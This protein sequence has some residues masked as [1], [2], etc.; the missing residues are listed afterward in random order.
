MEALRSALRR[1]DIFNIINKS[2]KKNKLPL[3]IWG[4]TRAAQPLLEDELRRFNDTASAGK[5]EASGDKA[6][7]QSDTS[8]VSGTGASGRVSLIVTYDDARA[9]KLYSDYRFMSRD[10][11]IYPAKD[12]LFY[13]ADVHGNATTQRRLEIIRRLNEKKDTV[14][15]TTVDGLMD[16]MPRMEEITGGGMSFTVGEEINIEAVRTSLATLGYENREIVEGEGQF[17][18]RGG[19]IDIYP[20]TEDCPYRIELF[21]DEIVSIRSFD[22]DSQRSI[23][24]IKSFGIYPASEFV[25]SPARIARGLRAIED[26]YEKEAAALK[27]KFHTEQYARLTRAVNTIKEE[28]GEFNSTTGLDSLVNYFYDE[29]VSF[30]DYL[31]KD[32]PVFIDEPDKVAERARVY[33]EEFS[34]SMDARLA[35]GYVLSKQADVL[36]SDKLILEMLGKRRTIMFSEMYAASRFMPAAETLEFEGK[37]IVTYSSSFESLTKDLSKWRDKDYSIVIASPSATRAKR[38][39]ANLRDNEIPAFFSDNRERELKAREVMVTTGNLE[40]GYELSGVKLAVISESDIFSNNKVRKKKHL[41]KY[42]GNQINTLDEISVGDYVVHERHGIGIYK[43]IEKVETD[44]RIRDYINIDYADGGKLFIPVEQLGVIGKYAGKDSAKPKLNKLGGDRWE[45]TR[46][47][48]RAHVEAVA[49]ELVELYAARMSKKGH[50]YPPDTVWQTEFEE[51]FPYEETPDQLHAIEDTKKDME[52]SKIMDRLICGDVGFGKTEVAIRAAFKAVQDNRQVAYL[53]PTTILAQQHFET[54]TDRMK[55][56]PVNIRM[57]SRF[58]TPK[59][60]KETLAGLKSGQVDIVIGTH[61]LLSKD[62]VFNDLG[63]LIIDEEQRFGVKHKEKIKQLKTNVDVLTLT[64]TP[65]PR[66][67]HMSLIGLRDM[68]ILSEAPVDRRA[69]QTY[70]MEYDKEFVKEAV[71]RE[72]ARKGQVYYVYNR[73]ENIEMIT[74]ELRSMLPD[75]RIEFAHGKM[76]ERDLETIMHDFINKEIDVLVSTT[77]I[78]TGLDIPNVN[79]II[80]HDADNFGLSQLYQLR[81]RVGRSSRNA[82]AFLMYRKD[83]M[84]REVAEK[85]LKAIREF[86]DLGSGYKISVKDL[87]IR[88]A[89]NLLGMDQSGHMEA[90]GYDLYV[91]MLNAA[92]RRKKGEIDPDD[93]DTSIDLPIDAYIPDTY[94]KVSFLKMELYKRISRI[95]DTDD[96]DAIREEAIDR[97]GDPPKPFERLLKVA[98]LKAEA[99]KLGMVAV[100]FRDDEVQYLLKNDAKVDVEAIPK[101]LRKMKRMGK[102]ARVISGKL[103]GFGIRESKLIQDEL[104]GNTADMVKVI[105]D[106]LIIRDENAV[107]D[108]ISG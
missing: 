77:I 102:T 14:I 108:S 41:P 22:A 80:I 36:Y 99:H 38:L 91:K 32:T 52:S 76:H 23:E 107:E 72:L 67:L 44:G 40:E 94:V 16:K 103:S 34:M 51:L 43:G 49:D 106:E 29:T 27:K 89:G 105:G 1:S 28:L 82:Y 56:Y 10:V 5:A 39:A 64:A 97:F 70:V 69:I 46:N 50:V 59:E 63:L 78:E 101:F 71:N 60:V 6:S 20:L 55:N 90:V 85:R 9:D 17:C 3:Y 104:L 12:A 66:T 31:P 21:G 74:S 54:F 92:I 79:T 87:E 13:Y 96:A 58:C 35:G 18:V 98:I 37:N 42:Q 61:R 88:G 81:G 30:L 73:V 48:A 7:G 19:I 83:K 24:E 25:L 93:F 68:S 11:F 2:I 45:K 65:I 95:K 4:L 75:A 53:V 84:I 15:I 33:A 57:L 62:L 47:N 8:S 100:Q 26:D 86:T